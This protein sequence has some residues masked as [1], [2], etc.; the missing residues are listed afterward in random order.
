VDTAASQ[1]A[2]VVP[3]APRRIIGVFRR[4]QEWDF[5]EAPIDVRYFSKLLACVAEEGGETALRYAARL[6]TATQARL[7]LA[8]VVEDV[9]AVVARLLPKSWN[10]PEVVRAQKGAH[11]ERSAARARRL[12]VD[13]GTTLLRGSPVRA[14]V[15]EVKRGK[16]D[17]L[18]V[19][20][21]SADTIQSI[22][23]TAVRL[24]RA[25]P[26]PVLFAHASRPRRRPRVLVAVDVGPWRTKETDALNAALLDVATWLAE[27]QAG[28]LHVLHVWNDY[29]ERFLRR[30]GLTD[31][32]V[33][34]VIDDTREAVRE[35]LE[36]TIAPFREH[37]ADERVHLERGDPRK[38]IAAFAT[39]HRVDLLV[40]GT[41]ART[42]L[43]ARVIGNTAE[44]VL[45]RLPCSML[46]VKPGGGRTTRRRAP[47]RPRE[48]SR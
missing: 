43:S 11:L 48:R 10:V 23:T 40:M 21:G 27:Q 22:D 45:G 14:L 7:T 8:D 30:G 36:H 1:S 42:G 9:P 35:E 34:D 29:V 44:T 39:T 13:A 4:S 5:N 6:A 37:I 26:C 19:G 41:V 47:H 16:H 46:V 31:D 38:T 18:V 28:E 12:G 3:V 20:A 17:L 33:Q 15:G 2:D 32:E 24:V 25:C